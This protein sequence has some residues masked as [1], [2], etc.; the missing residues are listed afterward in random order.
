M[1]NIFLLYI[2]LF[3]KILLAQFTGGTYTIGTAG[4]ENY[5]SLKAACD[6]LNAA[7]SI[8]GEVIFEITSDLTEPNNVALG[9]NTSGFPITFR[10]SA[11]VERTITFTQTSANGPEVGNAPLGAFVIGTTILTNYN[12]LIPTSNITISGL[13]SGGSTS[14]LTIRKSGASNLA[15]NYPISVVGNSENFTLSDLVIDFSEGTFLSSDHFAIALITYK[16]GS[17]NQYAPDYFTMDNCV[18][19]A[20]LYRT[21]WGIGALLGGFN[22]Y[23]YLGDFPDNI[24]VRNSNFT[25]QGGGIY[26]SDFTDAEIF[27]NTFSISSSSSSANIYGIKVESRLDNADIIIHSNLFKLFSSMG[28]TNRNENVIKI[29]GNY[30]IGGSS[31]IYNNMIYGIAKPIVSGS[32]NNLH[33]VDVS[34]K[35]AS[36]RFNTLYMTNLSSNANMAAFAPYRG[37]NLSS[38]MVFSLENNI[39]FIDEDDFQ[40]VGIYYENT[41]S[42]PDGDASDYNN[43]YRSGTTNS[44]TGYADTEG[45]FCSSLSDWQA[46]SS[47]GTHSVSKSVSFTSASDLHL[48]GSSLGDVDLIG[49]PIGGITTDIDGETRDATFPYMGAD[50][51]L[52]NPLPVELTSFSANISEK[53]VVLNWQTA[54]EVNNYGFEIERSVV[55]ASSD[56]LT[57]WEAIGFVEGHGN[58]NSPKEYT[59]VDD[60]TDVTADSLEYRLKQ[61]DTDGKFEYYG[62]TAKVGI[63][64]ITGING[65]NI[66]TEFALE[67]NYPNPFNPTTTIKY[68]IPA[69]AGTMNATHH[70]NTRLIVYDI[71]GREISTLVSKGQTPGNYE[72]KFDAAQLT[73][74]VYFYK[75]SSGSFTSTKKM[76]LLK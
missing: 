32:G 46:V 54:T 56:Q 75:I 10:P 67:Q 34:S 18:V 33:L 48:S 19:T 30:G 52:A 62:T 26:L 68:S 59:F 76:I 57:E 12:N 14:R 50:E 29:T 63:A 1:R 71:L 9:V 39:I 8:S 51:N 64:N 61:I 72:V 55:P 42:E 28:N 20:N 4:G 44:K 35:D 58:S 45:G 11:D 31:T 5:T 13:P 49:T 22:G 40:A 41:N 2:F 23:S 43:I 25:C 69:V 27:N 37:I 36:I 53:S 74:G 65:K 21:T 70:R 24:V 6:A 3:S 7:G 38:S 15:L 17:G 47:F 66:P 16:D 60:L 73:S